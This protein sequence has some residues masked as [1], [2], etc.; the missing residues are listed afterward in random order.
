MPRKRTEQLGFNPTMVRL[1]RAG[2]GGMFAQVCTFQS[3]N[4]AIAALHESAKC[5]KICNVSIPQWCDCCLQ[6]SGSGVIQQMG[7]NPTMVR[8]LPKSSPQISFAFSTFQSH[9][10]AIAA[11]LADDEGWK[12]LRFQS[13]N[14]A[15]AA[16]GCHRVCCWR[17]RVSIPQWCDCCRCHP[18]PSV[19]SNEVSIPQWCDCCKIIAPAAR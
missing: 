1:L 12:D 13:H 9:N 8:L 3:H 19:K 5:A 4:G 16:R 6:G 10:G 17:S 14:G 11:N 7:F 18:K 15:I 2:F